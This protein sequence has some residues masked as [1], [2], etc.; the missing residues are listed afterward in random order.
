MRIEDTGWRSEG[1][2]KGS[3][4]ALDGQILCDCQRVAGTRS[5]LACWIE[6]ENA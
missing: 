6:K 1:R 5:M 3:N 4:G 2:D